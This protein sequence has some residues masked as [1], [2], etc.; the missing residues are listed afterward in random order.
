MCV[1]G[2]PILARNQIG[3]INAVVDRPKHI[4]LAIAARNH[5]LSTRI[6]H[7]EIS[8]HVNLRDSLRW[9]VALLPDQCGGDPAQRHAWCPLPAHRST[10]GT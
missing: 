10:G 4:I 6:P 1:R 9:Q 8:R 3:I 5:L 2:R 7:R